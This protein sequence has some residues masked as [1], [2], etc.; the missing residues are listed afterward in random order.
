MK[1]TKNLPQIMP[2][3]NAAWVTIAANEFELQFSD[4]MLLRLHIPMSAKSK[5]SVRLVPYV[6]TIHGVVAPGAPIDLPLPNDRDV[7][8]AKANALSIAIAYFDEM[9]M[10]AELIRDALKQV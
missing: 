7:N 8:T 5:P 2:L 9:A 10:N 3:R 4:R 1:Y 6:K